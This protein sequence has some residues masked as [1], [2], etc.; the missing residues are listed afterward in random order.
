MANVEQ[1][2]SALAWTKA[3]IVT[4]VVYVVL[5]TVRRLLASRLG[6]N[7]QG[8]QH[9][10]RTLVHKMFE[11]TIALFLLACA[12]YAGSFFLSLTERARGIRWDI[13]TVIVAL[14]GGIWGARFVTFALERHLH[15]RGAENKAI[16]SAYTLLT[17]CGQGIV[18]SLVALLALQN[19]G[20]D[21]TALVAG[22]GIGGVAVALAVQRVL[23]DVLASLSIILDKPFEVGD[24]IAVG[25][26]SGSVQKIGLRTTRVRSINGEELVFSNSDLLASRLKN[27][28]AMNEKRVVL[29]FVV[30]YDVEPGVL[31]EIPETFKA[32][33]EKQQSTRY[34]FCF[35]KGYLDA[36]MQFEGVYFITDMSM[37]V[38]V[39]VQQDVNAGLFEELRR[40]GVRFAQRY[41]GHPAVDAA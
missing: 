34:D 30:D 31:R 7:E 35:F 25:D 11:G 17:A 10:I 26:L 32:L 28:R 4:L 39:R 3:A 36:G 24:W 13:M 6:E 21:V 15:Q 12:V 37:P 40:R 22:L 18:W 19:L 2:N 1:V 9:G 23:G 16:R 38:Q 27:F 20:V 29:T 5:T 41:G 14:Q 33:V 8:E